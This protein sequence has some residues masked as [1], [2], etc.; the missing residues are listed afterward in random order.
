MRQPAWEAGQQVIELQLERIAGG[1][2]NLRP[3]LL[4][5]ELVIRKS[6][7]KLDK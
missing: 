1:Q 2:A 7:L 3:V 5:P 6:S 4:A